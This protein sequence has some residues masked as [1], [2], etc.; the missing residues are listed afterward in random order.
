MKI[1]LVDK[2]RHHLTATEIKHIKAMF[3][4][5]WNV[6]NTKLK[7][8]SFQKIEGN[9]NMYKVKIDTFEAVTIGKGPE[10]RDRYVI[11]KVVK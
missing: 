8:Y 11:I 7:K 9:D 6:A 1:T 10:W 3:K 5:G 4:N 2:E